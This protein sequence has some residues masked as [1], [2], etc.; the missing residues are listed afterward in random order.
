MRYTTERKGMGK[1]KVGRILC[2]ISCLYHTVTCMNVCLICTD[3]V[4][5]MTEGCDK[6]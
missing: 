4:F 1:E 2:Y 5:D 6:L 3:I